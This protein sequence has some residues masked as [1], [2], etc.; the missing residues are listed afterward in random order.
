LEESLYSKLEVI[1]PALSFLMMRSSSEPYEIKHPY[2]RCKKSLS[3]YPEMVYFESDNVDMLQ[4]KFAR[5]IIAF[6]SDFWIL[7]RGKI[8]GLIR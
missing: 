1:N 8:N 5:L 4:Y 2:I 3:L 7:S 6:I